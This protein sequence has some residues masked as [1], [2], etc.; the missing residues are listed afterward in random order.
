MRVELEGKKMV[1]EFELDDKGRPSS[2]GKSL[3]WFTTGGFVPIP[4]SNLSISMT[5]IE[6]KGKGIIVEG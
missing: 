4:N 5:V 3:I 2:T 1:V 6:R